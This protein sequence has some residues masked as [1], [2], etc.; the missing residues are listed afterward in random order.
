[1][2]G[3][4]R[5]YHLLSLPSVIERRF[6]RRALHDPV[7]EE[8]ITDWL[9]GE[10]GENIHRRRGGIVTLSQKLG[11]NLKVMPLFLTLLHPTQPRTGEVE[12]DLQ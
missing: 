7:N 9:V 8:A 11:G 10:R 5:I 4:G 1:M 6:H 12:V 3:E 2:R